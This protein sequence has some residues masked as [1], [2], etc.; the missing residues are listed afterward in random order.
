MN[1]SDCEALD[2]A[3]PLAHKRDAFSIPHG[4]IYL[5]GNSLGLLPKHVPERLLDVAKRQ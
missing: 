1:R 2:R 5:D 4:M 3:D